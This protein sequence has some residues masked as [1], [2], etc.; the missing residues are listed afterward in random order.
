M[1]I[2]NFEDLSRE[3]FRLYYDQTFAEAYELVMRE[4][5][6]FPDHA[7]R[8]LYWRAC[9]ACLL[10]DPTQGLT[11]LQGAVAI[12]QWFGPDQLRH[13]PDLK[14]LQGNPE[15]EAILT[16]C[17]E[18]LRQAQENGK[19]ELRIFEPALSNEPYPLL[20]SLHGHGIS[21]DSFNATFIDWWRPI[22]SEGWLLA[23]P[24][25]AL[26]IGP[27]QY[28]WGDFEY[29]AS[30]LQAHYAAICRQYA[31]NQQLVI[32]GFS[33]GA[34]LSIWLALAGIL[35]VQG[36]I[37]VAPGGP[38]MNQPELWKPIIEAKRDH[39]MRFYLIVGE[40]DASCYAGTCQLADLL[41]A[42]GI[43][44]ELETH[45]KLAHQFPTAFTQS[46]TKALTFI[47]QN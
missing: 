29:V 8:L 38:Y 27:N 31:L 40:Q 3:V 15:F 24:Q 36:V 1:A 21:A 33:R 20:M 17:Q 25:S 35:P 47:F 39:P 45:P 19:P 5:T 23:V 16:I 7:N 41:I 14:A 43:A 30:E 4:S 10:N 32:G 11:V 2:L 9:F 34:M 37:A 46:L 26:I 18:R 12:G 44:C 22:V 42:H 6:H 13:D 28:G